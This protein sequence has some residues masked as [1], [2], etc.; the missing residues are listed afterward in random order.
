MPCTRDCKIQDVKVSPLSVSTESREKALLLR[1]ALLSPLPYPPPPVP[2][3][4]D[5][6][7]GGL[8]NPTVQLQPCY[9]VMRSR[10]HCLQSRLCCCGGR[11]EGERNG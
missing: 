1:A 8:P 11:G 9:F 4:E 2:I 6:V 7:V 3:L 5:D 10:V